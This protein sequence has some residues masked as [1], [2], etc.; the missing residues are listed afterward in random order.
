MANPIQ[1]LIQFVLRGKDEMSP[2]A[3]QSTEALEALRAKT[4]QLNHAMDDAKGARGLVTSLTNTQ[5]AVGLTETSLGRAEATI[6]DL[7]DALDKSPASKGLETSLKA[8][9]KDAATLRRTLDTLNAKLSEQEQA[10]KAAGVDTNKLADEEKRLA[11]EITRTKGQ[12]GD[13]AKALRDLERDQARAARQAA[14]HTSRVGAVGEAMSRGVSRV[15]GYAA[16]FMGVEAVLGLVGKGLRTVADAIGSMLK[17]GDEF[18]GL[19]TRLTSLM[20]SV[21]AG[22]QATEWITKFAKDTPLQ[23]SE[24]TDAFA[25]LKAYGLDPMNGTLQSVEDQSEK[26]GGGMERLEGIASAV[27]QAW[28]K[29]KLETEEILQLV[30]RGVPAWDMLAKVTGRNAGELMTLASNGRLG[31][32][33]IKAL[34]AEMGRSSAG[35]AAANMS[36]LTG[37]VSNLQ[38]TAT[39][40][41]NR[42]AKAGALDYVKGRLEALADTIE[43]MDEDGRL[44]ALA[45]S[46]SSAF[47]QG[48]EKIEEFG[49]RL[50]TVDFN[51]LVDESSAWLKDFGEKIDTVATWTTRIIAPFRV[52]ENV[53]SG[54]MK[55]ALM[56]FSGLVSGS[57]A[58]MAIVARAVPEMFGGDKLVAGLESARDAAFS[59]AGDMARGIAQDARDI[60][61]TWNSVTGQVQRNVDAQAQSVQQSVSKAKRAIQ[62]TSDDVLKHFQST[63]TG[64]ENAMAAVNFSDT[65]KQLDTVKKAVDEAFT[66]GR[67]TLGEYTEALNAVITRQGFLQGSS[68]KAASATDEQARAVGQLKQKQADL[69]E[70][71]LQHKI[72]LQEYEKQHNAVAEQLRNTG[73]AAEEAKVSVASFQ[74]AEAAINVIDSVDSLKKLQK[75]LYSA[76]HDGRISLE[77]YEKAHNDAALKIRKLEQAAGQAAPKVA[78]LGASLATLADVQDA[79]ANAKTDV[80]ISNIRAALQ[81][82]Y[83][84]GAIGA[85]DYNREIE[86]TNQRQQELKAGTDQLSSST[87]RNAESTKGLTK[88]Q[89]MMNEAM[90]DGIVTTEELRRISGQKMEDDRKGAQ[91]TKDN[92]AEAKA[93]MSSFASFYAGVISG[94]RSPLAELSKE[95]LAAFDQLRNISSADIKIDTTSLESTTKSLE[96]MREELGKLEGAA[97]LPGISGLGK[98]AL[99]MKADSDRVAVS[100]LEQ[101]QQLLG[102]LD[103]Y[104]KGAISANAFVEQAKAARNGM[105][106]L[107]DSDLRQLESTIESAKQRMQQLGEGSKQTLASLQEELAGLRGEQ[108][109]VD[110]SKFASRKAD[111][112]KQLADA[113]AGGD[114]NAVQNLMAAMGTLRQIEEETNNRRQLAEQQKRVEAQAAAQ[115]PAPAAAAS[116]PS[117]AWPAATQVIRLETPKGAVDV[118]VQSPEDGTA[119]L[120][121]LQLAGLRTSR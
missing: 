3:Q 52:A 120:D 18:E 100:F 61:D 66:A 114:L 59:I 71:Y 55:A 50:L 97:S 4:N 78:G 49:R 27:G 31:R 39:N 117:T 2:A 106:L 60:G 5:R 33:A 99:S 48:A 24:V 85:T 23:L 112:Q 47:V 37:L 46:L 10:A 75:A 62:S 109:A 57:L 96:Q 84:T 54:T 53:V 13:N 103:G 16:A 6:K 111:L 105:N 93:D 83:Q 90:E 89:Q 79:I 67:L 94:A 70:Q 88:S 25:L 29:Q 91:A 35:A 110:R 56:M 8:A 108:E 98:W 30:E 26:L 113:Q 76:Y 9:E 63:I 115:A 41:L 69:F 92:V 58:L 22:E 65:A 68:K 44:D 72:T 1:R 64:F 28:A 87:D 102:L 81:K 12:I 34:I 80:D 42:I 77:E 43:K 51:K 121:T 32:D 36:R 17:T 82:L 45:E 101:K 20:G 40:F 73:K 107:N 74:E 21:Q 86:K 15:V 14:E 118:A 19:Q 104:D 116:Q 11:A 119:L 38:D 7:R 95:A